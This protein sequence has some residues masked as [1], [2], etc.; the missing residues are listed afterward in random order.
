MPE[1]TGRSL[2]QIEGSL[3]EGQFRPDDFKRHTETVAA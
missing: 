1:L 2:E 3:R